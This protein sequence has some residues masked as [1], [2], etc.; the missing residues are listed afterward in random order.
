ML[1]N[2]IE[3]VQ[4]GV[5]TYRDNIAIC[6]DRIRELE[7]LVAQCIWID[8]FVRPSTGAEV[9]NVVR[10]QI[11]AAAADG[12]PVVKENSLLNRASPTG[13][14]T[15]SAE[16]RVGKECVSQCRSRWSP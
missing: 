7:L 14:T 6:N 5:E 9:Y 8:D 3:L 10:N 11:D 16:R 4:A 13:M 15:R 12:V 1:K 2:T